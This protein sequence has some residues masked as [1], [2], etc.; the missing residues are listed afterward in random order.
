MTL[1]RLEDGTH[2]PPFLHGVAQAFLP[3]PAETGFPTARRSLC[4]QESARR[5]LELLNLTPPDPVDDV[6]RNILPAY[7]GPQI[8][9]TNYASHMDRIL[10]ASRTDSAAQR[11]KLLNALRATNFVVA[12][13]TTTDKGWVVK[14]EQV[15]IATERLE[16]LLAGVDDVYLVDDRESCLRGESAR[17]L[18]E[19][20]GATRYLCPVP[21]TR[22]LSTVRLAEFRRAAGCESM[23]SVLAYD[24][25][26]LR[27]LDALLALLPTLGTAERAQLLWEALGE[28]L[29]RRGI[30]VFSTT[31]RWFYVYQRST[32][33]EAAFVR[34]L[35]SE[36]WVPGLDGA[37]AVPSAVNFETLGWKPNPV[38]QSK[39]IFR[40]P[41]IETLARELGIDP[42]VLELLKQL[43]VTSVAEFHARFQIDADEAS[44]ETAD[45]EDQAPED[46]RSIDDIHEEST[47]EQQEEGPKGSEDGAAEPEDSY[48]AENR[49][50]ERSP[51]KRSGPS[52]SDQREG[53]RRDGSRDRDQAG[54]GRRF[55]SYVAVEAE[56]PADPDGFDQQAR[57]E[58][59]ASAIDLVLEREPT[60]QRTPAG[61]KGF[62]LIETDAS[63]E[64]ERWV[65]VKA[66]TGTLIERPVG[67]SPAQFEFA[68]RAQDQYWLYVVEEAG[69]TGHS[70]I[71]KI[72][73][74][75][76]RAGSFTFDH[77]WTAV[78][79]IDD[80][81]LAPES[82]Y[83][84]S[85]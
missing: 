45:N 52:K 78:A 11:E 56:E 84:I 69:R 24:D 28:L 67:L 62:D 75:A 44:T 37:L 81:R 13:D 74:P 39:I 42:K 10:K 8:S 36:P 25:F 22:P 2:V 54:E 32:S 64:P 51:T 6:I 63:G 38:L 83:R 15:Y 53:T 50:A 21:T 17:A 68:R 3:G 80:C 23:S 48:F 14:P 65:E 70:R 60:L 34:L 49:G 31:Y 82:S 66:M 16:T 40:P 18:L 20:T 76:G 61:N 7:R 58:L 9:L 41:I 27:G 72:Q 26:T 57:M 47:E 59:E 33:F 55:I 4:S 71:V 35:N 43:G 1:V 85:S 30:G 5:L 79:E 19:A 77:G 46:S 29:E 12:I 73:N